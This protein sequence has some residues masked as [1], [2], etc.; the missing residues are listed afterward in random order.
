MNSPEIRERLWK[1][2]PP[3]YV[4][5]DVGQECVQSAADDSDSDSS[6]DSEFFDSDYD[7]ES[8]DDDL[9]L[10]NVDT[11]LHDNNERV[12]TADIEDDSQLKDRDLNLEE[13]ERLMLQY[14]FAAFNPAVDMNSPVFKIGMKFSSIEEARK[15]VNAYNIR[16][17][18][19]TRK[20]KNDKT[21]LHAICEEGCPWR[22]KIGFDLQRSGG[23]V[24][25]SY[26]GNHT[27][28]RVYEMRTLTAKFLCR[29][30]IDEFRYNQKMDLQSF[31]AKVQRKYNMCPDRWKLGRA[32][33]AALLEI[34][35][36]EEAQFALLRDYG[37]ELKRANPG[38]TFFLST[39]SVKELGTAIVK[40]HLAIMYWSYD[41]CKRGFL[42]RCRPLICVDGCHI[43]TRYKGVLLTAIG[44]NPNDCIFPIAMGM[45]EVECTSSLE[46]FITTLRD[47]LNITNTSPW[48]IMSDRQK[49]LINAVEKNLFPQNPDPALDPSHR[50]DHMVYMM[51]QEAATHVP[52]ARAH[53]PLPE[54][55]FVVNVRESMPEA[56]GR[57][58]T[59]TTRGRGRARANSERGRGR[60]RN[61]ATSSTVGDSGRGRG[62]GKST[63]RASKKRSGDASTSGTADQPHDAPAGKKR[64]GDASTSAT[65]AEHDDAPAGRERSNRGYRTRPGSVYHLMFGDDNQ[66]H[67]GFPDLNEEY[68]LEMNVQEMQLSQNAP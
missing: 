40:E 42:S 45:V 62:R 17:R 33:N 50:Q 39:N 56:T 37:E 47:D 54:S 22:L 13:G 28:E 1:D 2:D 58:T 9:F 15:A 41:A 32:R 36:N 4:A 3:T 64:T 11:D 61:R 20:T 51:G 23:Y 8:A 52:I 16:E 34:H 66:Q 60:G 29:Q 44:I 24:V 30:F 25:T 6:T 55:E 5:L 12:F 26:E 65:V 53:E 31:A 43:K 59:A 49:G 48:K 19:K 10:D 14:K 63:R 7:A 35:G 18:V 68:I 46:W 57:M 21:R 67:N 27:C 38:S